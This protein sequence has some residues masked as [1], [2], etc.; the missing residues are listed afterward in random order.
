MTYAAHSRLDYSNIGGSQVFSVLDA[1]SEF[2]QV[3]LDIESRHYKTFTTHRGLYRL[4]RLPFGVACAP[5]IFQRVV[6]DM[7]QGLD[8]VIV[9]IDEILV[10]GRDQQEHDIRM[11]RVLQRLK[12]ANLKLNCASVKF[13]KLV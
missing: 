5:E 13:E 4:K 10:F 1:E 9:Y 7:L 11:Q 2:H 3:P 8:G 6:D 12:D